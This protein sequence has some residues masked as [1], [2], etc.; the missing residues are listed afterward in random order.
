ME[1]N[2]AGTIAKF[3]HRT[4]EINQIIG[5]AVRGRPA[6]QHRAPVSEGNHLDGGWGGCLRSKGDLPGKEELRK[7]GKFHICYGYEHHRKN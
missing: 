3:G 2:S 7:A 5:K 1:E 6:Q 4:L